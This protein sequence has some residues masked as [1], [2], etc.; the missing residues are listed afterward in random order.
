MHA[1]IKD[2]WIDALLKGGYAQGIGRLCSVTENDEKYYCCLGVL[3]DLYE[4]EHPDMVVITQEIEEKFD[5]D[6]DNDIKH[7]VAYEECTFALPRSVLKWAGMKHTDGT[8]TD[9]IHG[10][11]SL[12]MLN[13]EHRCSFAD[14]ADVIEANYKNL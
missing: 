5:Y 10:E 12:A 7:E 11:T 9:D 14:I 13:D 6:Y 8:F 2:K 3:C 1:D 4:Q